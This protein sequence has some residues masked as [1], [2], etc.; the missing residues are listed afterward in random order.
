MRDPRLSI[1]LPTYN[2]AAALRLALAA[3]LG[4]HTRAASFELIVVDNN[5]TDETAALRLES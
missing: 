4:K 5:S 2:R 3:L 1:I